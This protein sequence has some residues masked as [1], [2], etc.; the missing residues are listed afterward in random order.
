[1]EEKKS[2]TIPFEI[3]VPYE[4]LEVGEPGKKPLIVYL[5]GFNQ[6]IAQFRNQVT[7]LLSVEAYHLFI[8]GPYPI[9]DRRR[10]K[11]VKEWGRAW[12]LYDGEQEQFLN[13][14][15]TASDFI[16]RVIKQLR[17][18]INTTRIT[19]MGYS[20]G[21]YLGGYFALS[22]PRW[23][24]ELVIIG[25]RVKT[26]AFEN[27]RKNYEHLKVLTLHGSEDKRVESDPQKISSE[28][29][30]QWGAEVTFKEIKAGHALG[31]EYI[32]EVK[33]WL[34]SIGYKQKQN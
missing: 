8:Q 11:P 13:S 12:Y 28:Q 22:N 5:H 32:R 17:D 31:T 1:M 15:E 29:L 34:S 7:N 25:G 24:D 33:Q 10:R 9:Y 4:L 14:L 16:A 20:M 26:E 3:A 2:T 6:N 30:S 19:V 23:I 21:G 27:S 18:Q